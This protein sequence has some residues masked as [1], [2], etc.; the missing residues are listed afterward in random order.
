M[1]LPHDRGGAKDRRLRLERARRVR[2]V[3]VDPERVGPVAAIEDA[4]GVEHWDELAT[5]A[6]A[7]R[8]ARSGRREWR[9]ALCLRCHACGAMLAVPCLR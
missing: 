2:A 3:E 4:V 6:K 1:E 7:E 8:H 5:D 9:W